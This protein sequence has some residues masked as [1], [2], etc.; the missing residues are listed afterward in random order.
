M[1]VNGRHK[2][3]KRDIY[4][5]QKTLKSDYL[6]TGPKIKEYESKLSQYLNSKYSSSCSSGTAGLHLA[7]L[8][9]GIKK[10]DVVIL[11]IINFISASNILHSIGAD[12]YFCD[13]EKY[14]GLI[15]SRTIKECIKKNKL[16]N[17]KAI[18]NCHISGDAS[19]I[20]E[21]FK[22]KKKKKF[23]LIDDAC[24]ALG[25]AYK[26]NKKIYKVG[27]SKHC[28]ISVFSTH[29]IK[30]ITTGEGGFVTTNNKIFFSK[31]EKLKSHGIVRGK[32][33]YKYD[34][35]YPGFNYRLSDINATL[36][37]AQLSQINKFVKYRN[38]LAKLYFQKLSK[39]KQIKFLD[40]NTNYKHSYHL[41]RI[42]ISN[43]NIKKT[44]KL[45]NYMKTKKVLIQKHYIPI[46]NFSF[47]KR[48]FKVKEKDFLGAKYYFAKTLSLPINLYCKEKTVNYIA[49]QISNFIKLNE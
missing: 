6:A 11:P 36:G 35:I 15:S 13:V 38:K 8:A 46:Y 2:I 18:V 12:I 17:I 5:V 49:K 10:N 14:N 40:K 20:V 25:S 21:I 47:Y 19:N 37:I 45:I 42:Q 31:I 23:L 27:C 9:A 7:F 22:L 4:S 26:F 39:I 28:D 34:I 24:H 43:F 29:A 16:K 41:F 30:T 3:N 48:A 1:I 32:F 33:H 44:N